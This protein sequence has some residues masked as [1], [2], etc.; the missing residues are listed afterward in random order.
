MSYAAEE[1][2]GVADITGAFM[3]GLA[4]SNSTGVKYVSNRFET[5]SYMLLSPVFFASIGLK[6]TKIS[7]SGSMIVFTVALLVV[8]ILAKII[9]C[10]LGAKVCR[11]S[12]KESLQIATGMISRGEVALIVATKGQTTG[13]MANEVF[14]PIVIMVVA[15]TILTPIFLKFVFK[16]ADSLPD[17]SNEAPFADNIHE[18]DAYERKMQILS[19]SDS[20][21]KN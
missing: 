4:I 6:M 8:A 19:L 1:F 17:E 9:G 5:L 3:A 13:L 18:R 7:M 11:Y 20:D 12:N 15:T 21:K 14:T 10:G 2:F 16:N